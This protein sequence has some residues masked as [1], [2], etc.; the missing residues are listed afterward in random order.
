MES[1]TL[2]NPCKLPF[3][4]AKGLLE[5]SSVLFQTNRPTFDGYNY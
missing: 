3:N 5:H 2:S 4:Y 1:K